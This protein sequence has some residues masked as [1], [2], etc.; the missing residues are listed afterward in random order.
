MFAHREVSWE[1]PGGLEE[2]IVSEARSTS[3]DIHLGLPLEELE[4]PGGEAALAGGAGAQCERSC[5]LGKRR[6]CARRSQSPLAGSWFCVRLSL[7]SGRQALSFG[8]YL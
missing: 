1:R 3:S 7:K 6:V 4:G 8:W 5:G 2:D